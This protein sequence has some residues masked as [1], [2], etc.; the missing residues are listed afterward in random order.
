MVL[1]NWHDQI[2][3]RCLDY[4]VRKKTDNKFCFVCNFLFLSIHIQDNC[5]LSCHCHTYQ[6]TFTFSQLE[7]IKLCKTAAFQIALIMVRTIYWYNVGNTISNKIENSSIS[8][9]N[10]LN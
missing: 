5:D 6:E 4:V 1:G 9:Q 3:H 2:D 7:T 8:F 10:E